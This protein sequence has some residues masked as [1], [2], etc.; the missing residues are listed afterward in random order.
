MNEHKSSERNLKVSLVNAAAGRSAGPGPPGLQPGSKTPSDTGTPLAGAQ[1]RLAT[2]TI[3]VSPN[4]VQPER[5]V[6][7]PSFV[8]TRSREL[9]ADPFYGPIFK[10]AAATVGGAVDCRGPP[11]APATQRP[12][13]LHHSLR[14][15]LPPRAGKGGPAVCA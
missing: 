14:L 5:H 3:A 1:V 12:A 4:P 6:L 7:S 13:G 9:P 2:G 10:G 8:A 15:A 11:V